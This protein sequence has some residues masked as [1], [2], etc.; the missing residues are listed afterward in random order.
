MAEKTKREKAVFEET[1]EEGELSDEQLEDA[2]GR[3]R[4]GVVDG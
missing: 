1:R 4:D 3:E 2:A